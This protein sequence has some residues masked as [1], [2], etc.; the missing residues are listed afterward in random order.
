MV[1][2]GILFLQIAGSYVYFIVRLNAIHHEMREEISRLPDDQLTLL[3][4]SREEYPKVRVDDY[5]AKVNEKMYDVARTLIRDGKVLVYALHDE[6]EDNLLVLLN[7]L[8]KRS[9]KDKKPVPSQLIQWFTLQFVT[10]D[11]FTPDYASV[12]VSHST[13]Y[14]IWERSFFSGIETPPPRG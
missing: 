11:G 5:E 14:L 8:V 1:F 13:R 4:L 9:S 10:L 3:T 2:L 12:W 6:A 7:E